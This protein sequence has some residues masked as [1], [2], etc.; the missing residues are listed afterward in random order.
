MD[1]FLEIIEKASSLIRE[2]EK[3]SL[4]SGQGAE[5]KKIVVQGM[6]ELLEKAPSIPERLKS[7]LFLSELIDLLVV[8]SKLPDDPDSIGQLIKESCDLIAAYFK[9]QKEAS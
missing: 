2:A 8:F 3:L 6:R 7:E 4:G 9:L 1:E 5:K